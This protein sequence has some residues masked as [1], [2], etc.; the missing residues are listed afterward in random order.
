MESGDQY[1]GN[2]V[3]LVSPKFPNSPHRK[4]LKFNYNVYG[5]NVGK[6]S[7]LDANSVELWHRDGEAKGIGERN[8]QCFPF[9]QCFAF[10]FTLNYLTNTRPFRFLPSPLSPLC[11]D[12]SPVIMSTLFIAALFFSLLAIFMFTKYYS[13]NYLPNFPN[14]ISYW[15][16]YSE[17]HIWISLATESFSLKCLLFYHLT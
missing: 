16:M 9:F 8:Q 11:I 4:C 7:I 12:Y 13:R 10:I 17:L 6:I 15:N 3:R 1:P 2:K 14:I 5:R